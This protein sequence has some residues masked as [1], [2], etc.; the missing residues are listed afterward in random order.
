[1]FYYYIKYLTIKPPSVCE[2][3]AL[4]LHS[5]NTISNN[6]III[7]QINTYIF[8]NYS[9]RYQCISIWNHFSNIVPDQ[10]LNSLSLY[11]I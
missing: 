5:H 4:M 1:M 10:N 7:L 8:G 9:I 6:Q 3:F 2:T 11:Q